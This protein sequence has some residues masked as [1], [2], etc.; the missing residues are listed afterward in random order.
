MM[1][2]ALPVLATIAMFVAAPPAGAVNSTQNAAPAMKLGPTP[3]FERPDAKALLR[4][5]KDLWHMKQDYTGALAKFN[6]AVR[7]DTDDHDVRLQRAHFFEAL[8][9]IVVAEDKGKFQVRAQLDFEHIAA[10]D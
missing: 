2:R 10:A 9:V 1:R 6:A 7:A 8:S 4:E 3:T 5:A